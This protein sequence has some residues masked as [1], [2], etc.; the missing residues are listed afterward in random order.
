[1]L[2]GP[3]RLELI[4]YTEPALADDEIRLRAIVTGVKRGTELLAYRGTGPAAGRALDAE[5][6]L[7][8]PS[9]RPAYPRGLGAWGVAEVVEVGRRVRRYR[10]GD[11]VHGNLRHRPTEVVALD[12]G[13]ERVRRSTGNTLRPLPPGLDPVA[14]L[15]CDPAMFALA[16]VHDARIKVGDA[17]AIFGMGVIGLVAVQLARLQGADP[18]VAVDPIADRLALAR[19][20]GATATVGADNDDP[21]LAIKEMTGRRGADVALEI[22]GNHA[23][24]QAAIRCAQTGGT[25]VTLG[26][27]PSTGGEALRLGEEWHHNRVQLLS[28]LISRGNAHRAAPLWDERRVVDTV[29]RLL[30]DGRVRTAAMVT[31]RLPY[32]RAPEA[33][34]LYD[35]QPERAIKIV[36]EYP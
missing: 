6:R 11:R 28:S 20:Y 36:L 10:V 30:T 16:A 22:S 32:A 9:D 2:T 25:V 8:R 31:H 33:Y 5:Y 35:R 4:P 7:F 26:F 18:L 1:V 29:E 17:V 3:R 14:A 19:A 21:G 12:E 15:F 24:L 34:D 27:Y 13:G 23:A